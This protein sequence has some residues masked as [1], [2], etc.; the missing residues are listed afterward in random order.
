MPTYL[1][2]S[3]HSPENCPMFN[4]KTR[5][6]YMDYLSKRDGLLKKHGIKMLGWWN[7]HLEHLIVAVLEMP[8]LDAFQKFTMEPEF[9]ALTAFSTYE[10]KMASTMEEAQK[11]LQQAK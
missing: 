10:M 2:I 11:M 9:N 8:S 3:K 1:M 7:I 4:E 6:V 5:K